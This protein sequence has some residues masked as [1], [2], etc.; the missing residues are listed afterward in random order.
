MY[1]KVYKELLMRRYN[2]QDFRNKLNHNL[3]DK[4]DRIWFQTFRI[5]KSHPK[6]FG[7]NEISE[8]IRKI[9]HGKYK[10]G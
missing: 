1:T 2:H 7:L 10:N 5:N 9:I 8:I 4:F 6:Y 3:E